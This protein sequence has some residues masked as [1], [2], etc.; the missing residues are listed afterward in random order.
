[1]A[2]IMVGKFASTVLDQ[3]S[4]SG[5]WLKNITVN[6]RSIK[7][8]AGRLWNNLVTRTTGRHKDSCYDFAVNGFE[9]FQ[10]FAGWCQS[11]HGYLNQEENGYF[12]QLDKD[13]LSDGKVYSPETCCFVTAKI[14]SFTILQTGQKGLLT[15]VR[16]YPENSSKFTAAGYDVDGKK[17]YL[18]SFVTEQA[19]H[20][21]W[22]KYKQE[23]LIQ[24]LDQYELEERVVT[25]L[26][27][28]WN[29]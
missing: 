9:D 5:L 6:G 28:K 11:Q 16:H 22:F 10:E 21:A 15:G 1:M 12:W 24:L 27:E 18:G 23:T 19:A 26:K 7:T 4:P 25:R 17:V 8:R 20:D 3:Q 2:W 14:N 13:I 29:L